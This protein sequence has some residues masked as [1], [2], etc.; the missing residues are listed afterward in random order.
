MVRPG[1]RGRRGR[2]ITVETRF[3]E[4]VDFGVEKLGMKRVR[5]RILEVAIGAVRDAL[6]LI[7]LGFVFVTSAAVALYLAMYQPTV[8]V[9]NVV[10]QKLGPAQQRARQAG[11]HLEVKSTIHTTQPANT[12]VKQW[13]PAGMTAKR[14]QPLRVQVSIGPRDLGQLRSAR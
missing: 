8:T 7:L 6:V 2:Q 9:P 12:I 3:E 10:G 4:V 11:L 13:P 1:R 5:A 14:G